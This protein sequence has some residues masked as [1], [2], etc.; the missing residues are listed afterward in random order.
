VEAEARVVER[1]RFEHEETQLAGDIES[2]RVL[3]EP[4]RK[5]LPEKAKDQV[6]AAADG[7]RALVQRF[8][9]PL[10]S[11]ESGLAVLVNALYDGISRSKLS[12]RRSPSSYLQRRWR[13]EQPCRT[14][15]RLPWTRFKHCNRA[16]E[17][18]PLVAE[19]SQCSDCC[20][21]PPRAA[22]L[23]RLIPPRNYSSPP[24][25][26]SPKMPQASWGLCSLSR[27]HCRLPKWEPHRS[28]ALA[29]AGHR[30]VRAVCGVE[31][32]PDFQAGDLLA[33]LLAS[34]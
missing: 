21:V 16:F 13:S 28:A 24:R 32:R 2:E 1:T 3:W 23:P 18:T 30:P 29:V 9:I 34:S 26:L 20:P 27:R 19:S 11:H 14:S 4:E 17:C 12:V 25:S 5:K 31:Q 10:F 33:D 6:A 22:L 8:D 15:W 7:L